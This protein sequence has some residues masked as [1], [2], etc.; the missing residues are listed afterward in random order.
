MVADALSLLSMGSVAL[1]VDDK[2]ELVKEVRR[3]VHLDCF[4]P[5]H[6]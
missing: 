6:H 1:I 5:L 3:L 2:K 4:I